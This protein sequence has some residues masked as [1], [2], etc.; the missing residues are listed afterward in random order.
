MAARVMTSDDPPKETNGSGTPVMG[1][2]PSTAPR[3]TTACTT[4]HVVMPVA[5]SMPKGSG[6]PMAARAPN[7]PSAANNRMTV[8]A[9]M[10]PSSSAMMAKMKSVWANGRKP[11]LARLA[12]SPTP[13]RP[14]DAMPTID[15]IV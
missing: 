7:T 11:H 8:P 9:P 2:T 3:F 15:W 14:P 4:S 13:V 6:A 1:S 12:P 5:S 10:R